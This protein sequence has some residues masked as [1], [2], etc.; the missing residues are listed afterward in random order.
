MKTENQTSLPFSR[1][2]NILLWRFWGESDEVYIMLSSGYLS[3]PPSAPCT[4]INNIANTKRTSAV[5]IYHI[6]ERFQRFLWKWTRFCI[7]TTFQRLLATSFG[8]ISMGSA[9]VRWVKIQNLVHFHKNLWNHSFMQYIL[10][11]EV[12]FVFAILFIWVQGADGGELRHPWGEHYINLV[13]F[14]SKSPQ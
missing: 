2:S 3:S 12:S 8:D 7:F 6:N 10:T 13:R 5:N 14:A 4:Q 11:A 9:C 1:G